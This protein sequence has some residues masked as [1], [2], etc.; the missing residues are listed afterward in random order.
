MW[1]Y[2][3][4]VT[5]HIRIGVV[6]CPGRQSNLQSWVTF[7]I[8]QYYIIY[9]TQVQ[10]CVIL[11]FLNFSVVNL[12][13]FLCFR[14][15]WILFAEIWT[16]WNEQT[17]SWFYRCRIVFFVPPLRYFIVKRIIWHQKSMKSMTIESCLSVQ[18]LLILIKAE[19]ER[20][21]I[22]YTFDVLF[23]FEYQ[24]FCYRT[25][26]VLKSKEKKTHGGKKQSDRIMR[27]DDDNS[28]N[29]V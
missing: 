17:F 22:Q 28:T 18:P 25:E 9:N 3:E 15:M 14:A 7:Q 10:G 19:R 2:V 8:R 24:I 4:S 29:F 27:Y 11:V 26:T 21:L 13:F 23:S 20:W 5:S 12:N 1:I 16:K 6:S